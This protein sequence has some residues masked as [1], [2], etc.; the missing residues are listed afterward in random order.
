MRDSND[1]FARDAVRLFS[2]A[3]V[4]FWHAE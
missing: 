1:T 2:R 3:A 4:L